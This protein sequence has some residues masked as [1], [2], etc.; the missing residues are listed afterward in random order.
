MKTNHVYFCLYRDF[1]SVT[2]AGDF[3]KLGGQSSQKQR[4][5]TSTICVPETMA[6]STVTEV[7]KLSVILE[8]AESS[9]KSDEFENSDLYIEESLPSSLEW[10][11]HERQVYILP[12]PRRSDKT[13]SP[14]LTLNTR[15][16]YPS[17]RSY[18]SYYF[19]CSCLHRPHMSWITFLFAYFLVI[20]ISLCM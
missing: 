14:R 8:T 15:G 19:I 9:P 13:S 12:R 11:R 2:E 18:I 17:G 20:I 16:S 10:G 5:D 4:V 6:V 1:D 3:E 7:R